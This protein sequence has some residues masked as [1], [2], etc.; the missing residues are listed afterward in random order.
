MAHYGW[1]QNT[2]LVEL[3]KRL[4][5]IDGPRVRLSSLDPFEIPAELLELFKT[6]EK[7][8]PHF[9]IALQSGSDSV[10]SGMRR[11]YQAKEFVEITHKI[12]SLRPDTFIGVDVIVGFPGEGEKEF[13]ETIDCLNQSYWTKLHVFS[14]SP[15]KGTSA[16]SLDGQVPDMVIAERS[17]ILRKMSDQKYFNFMTSQIGKTKKVILERPSK[18]YPDVWLGHTENYLPTYTLVA[19]AQAKMEVPCEV[20][21]VDG[22]RVWTTL[23]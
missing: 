11:I 13:Q 4:L 6:H 5:K 8:C 15:R 12:N 10:L 2:D 19:P 9:H 23:K 21:K 3:V 1:D 20:R 14:F 16:A 17:E 18:K 22:D 7:F